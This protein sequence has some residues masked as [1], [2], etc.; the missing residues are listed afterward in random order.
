MKATRVLAAMALSLTLTLPPTVVST[1]NAAAG[2]GTFC[3]IFRWF[4]HCR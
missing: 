2:A 4:P 1:I 3:Y